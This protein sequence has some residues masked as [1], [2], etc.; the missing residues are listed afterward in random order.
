MKLDVVTYI[1]NTGI[2][3]YKLKAR[4][5]RDLTV[6]EEKLGL[7]R[8]SYLF[9]SMSSYDDLLAYEDVYVNMRKYK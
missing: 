8:S 3:A 1:E 2:D 6:L 7:K 5:Y 9:D 4:A